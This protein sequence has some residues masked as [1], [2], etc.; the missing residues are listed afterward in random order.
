MITGALEIYLCNAKTDAEKILF[1]SKYIQELF[2]TAPR[3]AADDPIIG[4]R[5][6]RTNTALRQRTASTG[7]S[8]NR[9]PAAQR[10][11]AF[12]DRMFDL[13]IAGLAILG[14]AV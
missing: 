2:Y 6:C 5:V 3:G 9:E 7:C 14:N 11:G 12:L 4:K 10:N 1:V 13:S 8:I